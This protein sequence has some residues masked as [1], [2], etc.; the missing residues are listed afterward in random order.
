MKS[1]G[2]RDFEIAWEAG[3]NPFGAGGQRA[4]IFSGLA[5]HSLPRNIAFQ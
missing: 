3:S 5:I 1:E 2:T 4:E